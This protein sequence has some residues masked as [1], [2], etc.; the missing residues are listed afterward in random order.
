MRRKG[1]QY[2]FIWLSQ[3]MQTFEVMQTVV[4]INQPAVKALHSSLISSIF[5]FQQFSQIV[6]SSRNILP[7]N[8][9]KC[10]LSSLDYCFYICLPHNFSITEYSGLEWRKIKVFIKIDFNL[11]A[12]N[13]LN[14]CQILTSYFFV[15]C[16]VPFCSLFLSDFI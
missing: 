2:K 10:H 15:T 13:I 6:H 1:Y 16:K 3:G 11:D 12:R 14:I 7:Y 4:G 9:Q 5:L 8:L